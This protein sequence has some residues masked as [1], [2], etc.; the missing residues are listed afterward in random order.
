VTEPPS[1]QATDRLLT[2]REVA[3]HLGLSTEAVLRR[4]R[5]GEIPGFRLAPNVLRFRASEI[6]H[7]LEQQRPGRRQ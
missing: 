2:T 7:W 3:A 1:A 4:W 5:S 6:E